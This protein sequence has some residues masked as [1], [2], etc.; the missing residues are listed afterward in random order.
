M[1]PWRTDTTISPHITRH[2]NGS[3]LS[4]R[5]TTV[6]SGPY[7]LE[8]RAEL[9]ARF[10]AD[11]PEVPDAVS[12]EGERLGQAMSD[13]DTALMET[14][15]PTLAAL[16]WKL[17]RL[18]EVEADGYTAGWSEDYARQTIADYRRLLGEA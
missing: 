1:R 18:M 14:P 8:K 9:R 12:A 10:G 4:R 16:R 17:D 5:R 13:A 7:Y 2:S 15:A 6:T 11:Y 3:G